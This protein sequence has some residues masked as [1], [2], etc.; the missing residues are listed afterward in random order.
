VVQRNPCVISGFRREVHENCALLDY[1]AASIGNFFPTF[2][3]NLSVP[4]SGGQETK[5]TGLVGFIET[6]VRN[7]HF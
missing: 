3:Y 5:K 2:R 6:S 7:Y 4:S 1:Y